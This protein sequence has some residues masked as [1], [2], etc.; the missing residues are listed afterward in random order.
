MRVNL[1]IH[2][3]NTENLPSLTNEETMKLAETEKL[4]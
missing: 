2:D 3:G 4:K 1:I